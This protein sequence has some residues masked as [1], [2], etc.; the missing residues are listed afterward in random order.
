M[1]ATAWFA[2][3][4]E[5]SSSR[6]VPIR[7]KLFMLISGAVA[8]PV[9]ILVI[10]YSKTEH[11]MLD[12]MIASKALSLGQMLGDQLE[13]A[14]AFDD[15][16]TARKA[17]ASASSDE[18]VT[19][20]ALYRASGRPIYILG[21]DPNPPQAATTGMRLHVQDSPAAIRVVAPIASPEGPRGTLVFGYSKARFMAASER[22]SDVASYLGLAM[23]ALGCIAA[24]I[25]GSS[26]ARRLQRVKV[27][28][29]QVAAG[30]LSDAPL[31]DTSRDELGQ[32]ARAFQ[33]M[34]GVVERKVA[35]R[36][37]QLAAS[38]E[39]F[40]YLLEST[41]AIPWQVD[42]IGQRLVYIGPQ[43]DAVFAAEHAAFFDNG[44]W[45]AHTT[46]AES[47]MA[48]A[49]VSHTCATGE[50]GQIEFTFHRSDG[51]NISVRSLMSVSG[52]GPKRAVMG[53]MFDVTE[54]RRMEMDLRQHQKLES[55]GRLAAGVAHEINTPIQFVSDSVHF[56]G[57][58]MKDLVSIVTGQRALHGEMRA[59]GLGA[60]VDAHEHAAAEADLDY[61]LVNVPKA[62]ARSLEGLG[63]VAAIVHAMKEYAHPER[64][65]KASADINAALAATLTIATNEYKFVA[66]A[67]TDFGELPL[68]M[69]H[70][71]ELNQAFLNIIVNAAHAIADHPEA[72]G[73][74]GRITI[75][76]ATD[77]GDVVVRISDTGG[78]IPEAIQQRIFDPFFTTKEVG[79]GTGQGLAIA[80]RVVVD[81]HAGRLSFQTEPGHGTTFELRLPLVHPA[82]TL[83]PQGPHESSAPVYPAQLASA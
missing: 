3:L 13:P 32:M 53:F 24:W 64:R 20:L 26:F 23:F 72:A 44:F 52:E 65:E 35:E 27:R 18:D 77:N 21:T 17:F 40:R 10:Y 36:T 62:I 41:D 61:L 47:A 71:G 4:F 81:K 49:A 25:V 1:S 82:I 54:Q 2:R 51:R 73:V 33:V 60:A 28:A 14:V 57:D 8:I 19:Y 48:W 29:E 70:I 79:R 68:V 43:A 31:S 7:L 74:R 78:G 30:D 80:R 39:Q 55:V 50:D 59:C 5:R 9:L 12:E 69:C 83:S 11:R 63:R 38:R 58:A 15:V 56:V 6:V 34:V 66:D 16:Q 42:C 22:L 75:T 37:S 45:A 67:V 46:P 76:T